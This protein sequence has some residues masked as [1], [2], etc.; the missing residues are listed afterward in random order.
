MF[1][2]NRILEAAEKSHKTE[3]GYCLVQEVML[4]NGYAEPGY[5]DGPVALGNWNDISH[6]DKETGKFIVDDDIMPRLAK[7]LEK[8]GYIIDWNDEYV[9]CEDCGLPFR[10]SPDSYYWQMSGV[11]NGCGAYCQECI[12]PEEH[13]ESLEGQKNSCNTLDINPEDH[14]YLLICDDFK[15]GWHEGQ[16]ADPRLI[17]EILEKIGCERYLFNLD[18]QSQFYLDF[19]VWLHSDEAKKLGVAKHALQTN[20]V[21]GP[22]NSDALSNTLKNVPVISPKD[23]VNGISC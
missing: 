3:E 23:F 10:C 9:R 7:I 15:S 11:V 8:L 19:S 16:D 17:A 14:G 22:S 18:G 4:F 5:P 6:Y 13:L 21:N 2:I 20:E 12:D 1:D